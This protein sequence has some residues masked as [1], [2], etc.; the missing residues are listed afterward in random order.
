ML[1]LIGLGMSV[2]GISQEG[3]EAVQGCDRVYLETYT[4]EFPY[5]RKALEKELDTEIHEAGREI[6]ES[7]FLVK[8]AKNYDVALLIYGSPLCATTHIS[9]MDEAKKEG[10]KFKIIH[11]G[12]ILDAVAETGLQMYKFGK[13]TSMP[14]F[15]STSFIETVLDNQ[16]I[17]AHTI[18]LADIGLEYGKALEKLRAGA[19][20]NF[21]FEKIIVCSRVGLKDSKI[22][23]GSVENLGAKEVKPQ[24]CFV[25]PGKLHFIEEEFLES[26]RV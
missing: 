10:I 26:F 6:V 2:K 25:I 5:T 18:I 1:Y 19:K 22:M 17:G 21:Q 11:A 4:V 9:L 8:E 15:E 12:S 3:E 20:G 13:T 7:N 23:Y 14:S 16:K 24:Y